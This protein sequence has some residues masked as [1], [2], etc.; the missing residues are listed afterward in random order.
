MTSDQQNAALNSLKILRGDPPHDVGSNHCR[1][2]GYYAASLER[3]YGM[4]LTAL[5][6]WSGYDT[7]KIRERAARARYLEAIG[8]PAQQEEVPERSPP[9]RGRVLEL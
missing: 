6:M 9:R 3:E 7:W 2:D 5:S 8:E 4:D 1:G